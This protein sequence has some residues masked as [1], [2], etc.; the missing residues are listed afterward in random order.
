MRKVRKDIFLQK[1]RYVYLRFQLPLQLYSYQHEGLKMIFMVNKQWSAW[2]LCTSATRAGRI[3][4]KGIIFMGKFGGLP[5]DCNVS[6]PG[7]MQNIWLQ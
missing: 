1:V 6:Q 7:D 5:L 3:R 4:I 2:S